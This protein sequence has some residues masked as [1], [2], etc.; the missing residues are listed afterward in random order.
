MYKDLLKCFTKNKLEMIFYLLKLSCDFDLPIEI[1][2]C[3]HS[4]QRRETS[5]PHDDSFLK[6]LCV[7]KGNKFISMTQKSCHWVFKLNDKRRERGHNSIRMAKEKPKDTLQRNLKNKI[8]FQVFK[9]LLSFHLVLTSFVSIYL[10]IMEHLWDTM[11]NLH[12]VDYN[13]KYSAQ[14]TI[15]VSVPIL[16]V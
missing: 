7:S 11:P 4:H 9:Y 12:Y 6:G 10:Q 2:L 3:Y 1:N 13:R 5:N 14:E 8:F 15:Q 16:R